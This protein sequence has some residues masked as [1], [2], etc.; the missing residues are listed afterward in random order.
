MTRATIRT[1]VL[2]GI[3]AGLGDI[4][5]AFYPRRTAP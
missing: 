4:V 3:V 2:T 1:H 5:S